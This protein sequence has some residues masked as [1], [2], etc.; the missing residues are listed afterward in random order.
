VF[1]RDDAIDSREVAPPLRGARGTFGI[2]GSEAKPPRLPIS[3]D[4]RSIEATA[5]A[6]VSCLAAVAEPLEGPRDATDMSEARLLR[7]EAFSS[8]SGGSM[9]LL[10]CRSPRR[11]RRESVPG[12]QKLNDAVW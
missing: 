10:S 7:P 8:R 9:A 12:Q 6:S 4:V 3:V 11:R 1:E 5:G 2:S